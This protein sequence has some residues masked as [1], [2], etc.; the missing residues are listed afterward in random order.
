[1]ARIAKYS[2]LQFKTLLG[3]LM[4]LCVIAQSFNYVIAEDIEGE[5]IT[6]SER[7][8]DVI[9][10]EERNRFELFADVKGFRSAS[11]M[12]LVDRGYTL[13]IIY[14]D[15]TTGEE[16]VQ[17]VPRTESD[18]RQ[19]E[20]YLDHFEEIRSGE[21]T[22]TV[23]REQTDTSETKPQSSRRIG[24]PIR[25]EVSLLYVDPYSGVMLGLGGYIAH[26]GIELEV[27]TYIDSDEFLVFGN[28]TLGVSPDYRII[29]FVSIGS[30][31][32]ITKLSGGL[33]VKITD[34]TGIRGELVLTS[35]EDAWLSGLL[36]GMSYFFR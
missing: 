35:D 34:K 1:M 6:I 24:R 32:S 16:A 19:I 8:G 20:E 23:A 9:D 25:S 30:S 3:P 22:Y 21:Y 33:K 27:S 2:G 36:F 12:T 29:P 14:L 15:E 11:F 31:L 10:L 7:V 17:L 13:R 5:V 26:T 4:A 28:L 18:I